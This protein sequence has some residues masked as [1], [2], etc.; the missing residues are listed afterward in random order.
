MALKIARLM[1]LIL[2]GML[3]GNE[4]GGWVAI[5]PALSNLPARA[6]IEAEQAVIVAMGRSCRSLWV[7]RSP[8]PSRFCR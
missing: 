5:H 2:A 7:P 6:H 3:I 1:N 4:F 8:R